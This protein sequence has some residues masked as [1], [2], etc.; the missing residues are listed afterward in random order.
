MRVLRAVAWLWQP[1]R[2]FL[3]S[4][5]IVMITARRFCVAVLQSKKSQQTVLLINKQQCN[6]QMLLHKPTALE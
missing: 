4:R 3:G 6:K 5:I 1:S 2:S